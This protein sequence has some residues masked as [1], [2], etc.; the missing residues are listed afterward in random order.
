VAPPSALIDFRSPGP[1]CAPLRLAFGTPR[2]TL[3][4][5]RVEEVPSVLKLAQARARD[6]AWCVG[7]LHYEAAG[8]FDAA[9]RSH[10]IAAGSGPLAR[11]LVYDAPL[12]ETEAAI[13]WQFC[14]SHSARVVWCEAP[15]RS[16]FDAAIAR[17]HAAIEAGELYQV[18]F[19]APIEGR[20]EGEPLALFDAMR[21]AQ[22][23]AYAAYIAGGDDADTVLSVSPE[24]FFDWRDGRLLASPMKGTGPRG[25]GALQDAEAR[26]RLVASEKERAE[27]VM[28]VDLLRNDLS[29]V[30]EPFSVEVLRLFHP[31]AWPTL[32]QLSSEIECRT[33]PGV[34]LVD[35]FGAL[36]PCGSV[37]GAPKV[38]AMRMI[39]DLE[40]APRGVYCGAVG[41]I[42]PGGSATFNV[43]IRT[44]A[45]R[46]Q[47]L[48]CGIGS[49]NTADAI[50]AYVW[51]ELR[52]KR[53]FAERASEPLEL[54]ETLRLRDGHLAN[55][56]AHLARMAG[57]AVHFGF[58]F[59]ETHASAQLHA[60][61]ARHPQGDWRVRLLCDRLGTVRTQAFPLEASPPRLSVQLAA[62]PVEGSDGEFFRFKTTRRAHYEAFAP[63]TPALFDTLLWNER[64]ELTEFTRG[65]VALRIDA[66]WLT[67]PLHCG[68]LPGVERARLLDEGRLRE[69]VLHRDDLAQAQAFAFFNSLRGWLEVN[70]IEPL[71]R[72]PAAS[73]GR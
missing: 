36:F 35:V 38:Q 15:D 37:T 63:G 55:E 33:R 34:G 41:V 11:F 27:N 42:R 32:W 46:G 40:P 68:L 7:S 29:R 50:A 44:I 39:H 20:L 62:V 1:G 49:G 24:L 52:Q 21:R 23:N 58:A 19:T 65:N 66:E 30:A 31:E 14:A 67:P 64:G 18:N 73:S 4:A 22:P 54:L 57:A 61:A 48:R 60:L 72:A 9:L 53:A 16:A 26:E 6:G 70:M 43:P 13:A 56:Q 2:E 17:I 51:T 3:V 47:H 12:A 69:A 10:P 45:L 5:R 59:D 71:S 25:A 28:I 8:A